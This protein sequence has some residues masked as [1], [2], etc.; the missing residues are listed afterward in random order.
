MAHHTGL[1]AR[2]QSS[3][4][5]GLSPAGLKDVMWGSVDGKSSAVQVTIAMPKHSCSRARVQGNIIFQRLFHG[6]SMVFPW[7]FMVF[8]VFSSSNL[9]FG[10]VMCLPAR[11]CSTSLPNARC[12]WRA[13]LSG[14]RGPWGATCRPRPPRLDRSNRCGNAPVAPGAARYR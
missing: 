13:S 4:R 9:D 2:A 6:F 14:V 3:R 10:G 7:F 12:Q 8:M 1:G 11:G 5:R